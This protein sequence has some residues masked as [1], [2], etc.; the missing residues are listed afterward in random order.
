MLAAAQ[1]FAEAFANGL[2]Q[3]LRDVVAGTQ[4]A[5]EAFANFLNNIADLLIQTAATMIQQYIL[6]A[7]ARRAAGIP[8]G[9]SG[10]DFSQFAN[11]TTGVPTDFIG[12][13]L[14]G[15]KAAGG[16]TAK[17]SP[18]IV[19]ENGSELFIPNV[20]GRII[21]ADD[22]EAARAAMGGG[23]GS[24]SSTVDGAFEASS[25]SVSSVRERLIQNEMKATSAKY[26]SDPITFETIQIGSMDV[27]TREEAEAIGQASA[28]QA[29]AQVFSDF[30]NRPSARRQV[31][32]R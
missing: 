1:P 17:G 5:E 6:I 32:L 13:G 18:Y 7:I 9:S 16:A 28:Q 12:S 31:G 11:N 3:G 4:T 22:F 26:T 25:S 2:T 23:G 14:S 15:F 10:S 24:D 21:P 27:V 19:G 29:R 20:S 30:R 8:S